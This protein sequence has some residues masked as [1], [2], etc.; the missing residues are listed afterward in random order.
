[1]HPKSPAFSTSRTSQERASLAEQT[2]RQK[3][4]LLADKERFQSE[5]QHFSQD[6][7]KL[8]RETTSAVDGKL[9][10]QLSAAQAQLLEEQRRR[11]EAEGDAQVL[12]PAPGLCGVALKSCLPHCAV[13]ATA[14]AF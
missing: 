9:Q 10:A 6:L 13:S 11:V 1:M 3:E 2:L 8:A 7:Q 4:A 14:L 5:V 12:M